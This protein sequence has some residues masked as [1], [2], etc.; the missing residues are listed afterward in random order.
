MP[1]NSL[2]PEWFNKLEASEKINLVGIIIAFLGFILVF[3]QV[4]LLSTQIKES[5][6][7]QRAQLLSSLHQRG[8]NEFGT[9]FQKLEFGEIEVNDDNFTNSEDQQEI[10]QLLSFIELM[11][12]LEKLGLLQFNEIYE[13][14]GYY[15]VRVYENQEIEEYRDFLKD[16]STNNG[17]PED[18]TFPDFE[19]L[20]ERIIKE[21]NKR[22]IK[23]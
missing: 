1:N 5:E 16:F 14:F 13:T 23:R 22:A 3:C 8:F 6:Y 21:R 20:S 7:S 12:E 10:V 18:L 9:I 4:Q 17:Y 19:M 11:A 2:L 15:I